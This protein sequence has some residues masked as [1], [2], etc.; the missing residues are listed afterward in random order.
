[1][2]SL[3]LTSALVW[4]MACGGLLNASPAPDPIAGTYVVKGGGAA[5]DVFNALVDGFRGQHPG[6]KAAFED[7]GSTAGM[8]LVASGDV[9]LATSSAVVPPDLTGQVTGVPVGS[10]G[11]AVIVNASNPI[12]GLNKQQVRD[13]F[14]GTTADWSALGWNRAKI[15]VVVREPTSAL[16]ANFDSYFF[17]GTAKFVPDA[18]ELNSGPDVVRAVASREAVVGMVTIDV[19]M[20]AE[21]AIRALAI[22]GV[23][24]TK[25]N[26]SAG[27][28]PVVR[29][30]FLVYKPA[31][32]RKGI[33][34]FID[35]VRSPAGQRIIE[36]ATSG[37]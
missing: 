17:G 32:V 4:A 24:P 6:F 22:D 3:L 30:L 31:A 13:V 8:K 26:V 14:S 28:Y 12:T 19:N 34:A 11:T 29:P 18:I 20:R 25:E 1:M 16:R 35:F 9:D 37:G 21:K 15:I 27:K 10:S 5:L 33:A 36:S 7:I 2:R 23:A